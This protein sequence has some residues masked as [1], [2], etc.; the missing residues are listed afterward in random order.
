MHWPNTTQA[1][2]PSRK[3]DKNLKLILVLTGSVFI[4]VLSF[5][6]FIISRRYR[7]NLFKPNDKSPYSEDGSLF[8]GVSVFSYTE[9]E[10]ATKNF[11]PSNELGDGGFGEVYYGKLQGCGEET[12]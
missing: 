5:A 7:I 1:G 2:K 4:L 11:D 10:D 12:L 6:I 3:Q 8:F 9:L